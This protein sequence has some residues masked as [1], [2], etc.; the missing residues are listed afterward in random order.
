[1]ASPRS[2]RPL[3]AGAGAA[4]SHDYLNAGADAAFARVVDVCARAEGRAS[5]SSPGAARGGA[6]AERVLFSDIV[7]KIN[8]KDKCVWRARRARAAPRDCPP[9]AGCRQRVCCCARARAPAFA[10]LAAQGAEALAGDHGAGRLQPV[11]GPLADAEA[12][13]PH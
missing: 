11:A 5:A 9:R 4:E 2:P 12:A 10:P 3:R 8:R 6:P 13:H 1:M 7:V